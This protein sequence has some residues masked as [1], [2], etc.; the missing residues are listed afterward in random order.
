MILII[1]GNKDENICYPMYLK[2]M[3][4][5]KLYFLINLSY[6]EKAHPLLFLMNL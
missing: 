1:K 6:E 5:G 3:G 2:L 4:V